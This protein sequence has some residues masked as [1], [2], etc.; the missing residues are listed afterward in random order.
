MVCSRAHKGYAL[1]GVQEAWDHLA[2]P[3]GE[4]GCGMHGSTWRAAHGRVRAGK[5]SDGSVEVACNAKGC[6]AHSIFAAYIA[7]PSTN[8]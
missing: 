1:Q 6:I 3:W 5:A 4:G 7:G 2:S 8:A